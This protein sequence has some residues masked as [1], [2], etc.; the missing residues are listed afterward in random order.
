[1]TCIF[2][3]WHHANECFKDYD[4]SNMKCVTVNGKTY[5]SN[6]I[7]TN[8]LT[9]GQE[10]QI[11]KNEWLVLP[12]TPAQRRHIAAT[13]GGNPYSYL[14]GTGFEYVPEPMITAAGK[15]QESGKPVSTSPIVNS[16]TKPLIIY[17][18]IGII[19]LAFLLLVM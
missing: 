2:D 18:I 7:R 14:Y 8:P 6:S 5:C 3:T 12:L 4:Y 10:L 15:S 9:G 1:M 13:F 17:I 11:G 19:A 16:T